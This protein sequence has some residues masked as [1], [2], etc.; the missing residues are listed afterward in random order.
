MV[1]EES[2]GWYWAVDALQAGGAKV[3]LAHPLRPSARRELADGIQVR[4]SYGSSSSCGPVFEQAVE[5]AGD[6]AG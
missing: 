3:H 6:V 1:L 5:V 4:R 2:Y